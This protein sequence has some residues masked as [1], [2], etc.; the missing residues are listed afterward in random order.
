LKER[1]IQ[2]WWSHGVPT[3]GKVT[4]VAKENRKTLGGL[5]RSRE[6]TAPGKEESLEGETP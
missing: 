3:F 4:G 2:I 5:R 1:L 6:R